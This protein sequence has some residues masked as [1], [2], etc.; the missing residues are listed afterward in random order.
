MP[1][2]AATYE[3]RWRLATSSGAWRIKSVPV[4]SETIVLDGV[5]RGQTYEVE[6]RAVSAMGAASDWV[7][8]T[9]LV[10]ETD[11]TGARNLPPVTTGNV[12]S[13]WVDGAAVTYTSTDTLATISVSAGSLQVGDSQIAYGAS[14]AVVSGVAS[15]TVAYYLYYDDPSWEGGSRT[16]GLSTDPVDSMSD[17]GRIFITRLPVTFAAAGGTGGGGGSI[18]GGGG[19]SGGAC[20][21]VDSLL[22]CGRRAGDIK[23]GDELFLFD[24]VTME[25]ATGIVTYSQAKE[26][27]CVRVVTA[28]GD[29]LRC[30]TTAPIPTRRRGLVTAPNLIGQEI[31]VAD[32]DL[33]RWE[34]VCDVQNI[35]IG[36]VQHITVG[37]RCFWA[38]ERGDSFILHHNL[39][40]EA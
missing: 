31:L 3:I 37:D 27:P 21:D 32:G 20:V 7:P 36:L 28:A 38:S 18:G 5:D 25:A 30:S 40:I 15:A 22:P 33:M 2:V 11:N 23:V 35:G 39:K 6:A 8:A 4:T 9:V 24:P 1:S 26:A 10:D 29:S 19:G 34:V 12:A 16:L 14:S 13:R 17:Y